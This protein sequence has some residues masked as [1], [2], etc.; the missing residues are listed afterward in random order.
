MSIQGQLEML[1]A[2]REVRDI[3]L[4][5]MNLL[6]IRGLFADDPQYDGSASAVFATIPCN[7]YAGARLNRT[8]DACKVELRLGVREM[9]IAF[10]DRHELVVCFK[11]LTA[12]GWVAVPFESE[13][14][15]RFIERI[16]HW[17]KESRDRDFDPLQ[18][19]S[20]ET[21]AESPI[22]F[23]IIQAIIENAR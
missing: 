3:A 7:W 19:V 6:I 17:Y 18:A 10:Y 12:V 21:D 4:W 8:R 23:G 2:T 14:S 20:R 9:E 15:R 16:K 11:H 1:D 22:V 5:A 13:A